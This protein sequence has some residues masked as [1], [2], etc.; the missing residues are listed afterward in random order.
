M[1]IWAIVP[2][3]A[4]ILAG[5]TTSVPEPPVSAPASPQ[6][7]GPTVLATVALQLS[8]STIAAVDSSGAIVADS[9]LDGP[10]SNTLALIEETLNQPPAQT[11]FEEDECTDARGITYYTWGE[12]AV[13]VVQQDSVSSL[14][15]WRSPGAYRVQFASRSIG[16]IDLRG[17]AGLRVGDDAQSFVSA[18]SA[19]YVIAA[20]ESAVWIIAEERGTYSNSLGE[21]RWGLGGIVDSGTVTSW[22]TPAYVLDS[23]C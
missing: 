12:S 16:E 10:I 9:P 18:L 23:R 8:S 20:S 13:T 22:Q 7:T 17:A 5:C 14:A 3:A 15:T 19:D 1:R 6:S 11:R 2:L 4:L 21:G